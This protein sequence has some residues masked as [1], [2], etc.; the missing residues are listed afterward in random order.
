MSRYFTF[1]VLFI[2]CI[3]TGKAQVYTVDNLTNT[4]NYYIFQSSTKRTYISS[5]EGLN[6]FD[7]IHNKVYGPN[8]YNL[9]DSNIQ[10][11]FFED[12]KGNVWFS[13]YEA[14]H[15]YVPNKDDFDYYFLEINGQKLKNDYRVIGLQGDTLCI[16]TQNHV[17]LWHTDE[18][19]V[20]K[21]IYTGF[22][23]ILNG[24]FFKN[25]NGKYYVAAHDAHNT[26]LVQDIFGNYHKTIKSQG[27]KSVY[28]NSQYCFIGTTKGEFI[29]MDTDSFKVVKTFR[30]DIYPITTIVDSDSCCVSFF[31]GQHRFSYDIKSQSIQRETTCQPIAN[32]PA[33]KI[34][35]HMVTQDSTLWVCMPGKGIFFSSDTKD[36]FKSFPPS[37]ANRTD[38]IARAIHHQDS[39]ILLFT[40]ENG[41]YIYDDRDE[42]IDHIKLEEYGLDGKSPVVHK[43]YSIGHG[44]YLIFTAQ[45]NLIYSHVSKTFTKSTL[46]TAGV[47]GLAA[48][49]D[50]TFLATNVTTALH[51][52]TRS[53]NRLVSEEIQ[54]NG[55]K[56]EI[57]TTMSPIGENLCLISFNEKYL[58][59]INTSNCNATLVK[60]YDIAGG[61]YHAVKKKDD[62]GYYICN[63]KG[64]FEIDENRDT[65]IHHKGDANILA[66]AL[67]SVFP[68]KND[69]LWINS[70]NAIFKYNPKTQET[71]RFGKEDGIE[72][73]EFS[74]DIK[75]I[76][77][78]GNIYLGGIG[79]GVSYFPQ[80]IQVSQKPARI[81]VSDFKI[82]DTDPGEFGVSKGLN[83]FLLPY[84]Q[85]T[86]SFSFHALDFKNPKSTRV[87][88]KLEGLDKDYILCRTYDGFARYANLPA[89]DY[90]LKLLGSNSD[91]VWNKNSTDFKISITPP[92]WQRPWFKVG[93]LFLIGGIAWLIMRTYYTQQLKEKDFELREQALV[94]EKQM[95]LEEER[96]RIAGEMHDD[97][98]GGLTNI[99]FLSQ[100]L[101]RKMPE[102]KDKETVSKIIK[103]TQTLVGNMSEIIWAMNSRYTSSK[104]RILT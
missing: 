82:N 47:Q 68:D 8:T 34:P 64:L 63:A 72:I 98:G 90:T 16:H 18:L 48:C 80:T 81:M 104:I 91:G 55:I 66:A 100:K 20:I 50:N 43:V 84:D 45:G 49:S 65:I 10:S 93:M 5:T 70:N 78:S 85:N 95:A 53:N 71:Y 77:P 27:C 7:G 97:L 44:K 57:L 26:Y 62:S 58:G 11:N 96:T 86:L 37:R 59:L 51:R 46:K 23:T 74:W 89:G 94:I 88:Y 17:V 3:S 32:N 73:S 2:L 79:G 31:S 19:R 30:P 61:L 103:N 4:T 28:G 99:K 22:S 75:S 9:Y 41:L 29:V 87:K 33:S 14:L 69:N 60:T 54:I 12:Q 76:D 92:F 36:R 6:I 13:T 102:G 1:C 52:I 38:I 40:K 67:F 56:D 35:T 24:V 101:Q 83:E 39:E 42:L 15:R 21:E 25:Q